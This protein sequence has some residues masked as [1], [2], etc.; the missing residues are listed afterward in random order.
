MPV[1][2]LSNREIARRIQ[3]GLELQS[4]PMRSRLRLS[5]LASSDSHSINLTFT[6]SVQALDQP[7]ERQMLSETFLSG[8]VA[9]TAEEVLEHFLPALRAAAARAVEQQPAEHWTSGAVQSELIEVLRAAARP[10]AFNCGVELVAPFDVAVESPSLQRQKLETMQRKAVERRAADQAE[11]VARAATLL[12]Q[13]QSLRDAAPGLS[14]GQALEQ[15]NPADRGSMLETLLMASASQGGRE[16]QSL[17]AVAGPNLVR[18][19]VR[20]SPPASQLIPLPTDLGPLRSVQPAEMHGVRG[21]LIGAQSGVMFV[22][23]ARPG[24]A[25]RYADRE[26]TS[27]LGFNSVVATADMIWATH[28]E[29]GVVAWR[30]GETDKPAFTLRPPQAGDGPRNATAF[31]D[32][33]ILYSAGGSLYVA[34][35]SAGLATSVASALA[36]IIAIS[37]DPET[38][39]LIRA[40]GAIDRLDRDSFERLRI[41]QRAGEVVS[42]GELPWLGSRR[43]LLATADG[44]MLCLGTDDALVTQYTSAHRGLRAVSAAADCIAGINADRTRLILWKSWDGRQPCAEVHLVGLAR[45]R[46]ADLCFA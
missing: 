41:E 12:K 1:M 46:A 18:I 36:P 33:R 31:D 5:D 13:F 7:V 44:P 26:V 4:E 24:E 20:Q 14:P 3:G 27:P 9:V 30:I 43:L 45:H 42:A 15:I 35:R 17:Y 22:D 16:Q 38:I 39:S 40:N 25:T 8:R 2:V 11:H 28:G 10:I 19:D 6:C 32:Q 29:A 21:L 37:L 34:D 23:P